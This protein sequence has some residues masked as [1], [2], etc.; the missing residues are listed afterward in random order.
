MVCA[1]RSPIRPH[2]ATCSDAG[3]APEKR[4][5]GGSTPPL[6]TT[7]TCTDVRLV[8]VKV[9]LVG[10]VV[11]FLGHLPQADGRTSHA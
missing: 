11:S 3:Y 2:P 10:L 4:K 6:T 5:V 7:L 9:Q 1:A 8:I